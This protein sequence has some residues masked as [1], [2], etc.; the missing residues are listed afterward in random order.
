[1]TNT[2]NFNPCKL[3]PSLL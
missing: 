3:H 1:M 2:R